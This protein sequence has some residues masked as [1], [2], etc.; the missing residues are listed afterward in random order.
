MA[1]LREIEDAT[2]LLADNHELLKLRVETLHNLLEELKREHIEAIKQAA[3]DTANAKGALEALIDDSR[4]LFAKPKS[5]I[6]SGIRV[7]LKKGSGKVEYED[8]ALVIK[9][10][11]K[12]F[13]LD[14][15]ETYIKTTEKVKK[16]ALEDLDAATL[17]KLGVTIEG[18]GEVV[19]IKMVAS[20]VDKIVAAM[21][22]GADAGEDE[23]EDAA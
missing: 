22:K 10:L 14:H 13:S 17:K 15:Q 7:G 1:T 8:E 2:R 6:I 12:L 23:L 3:A 9:R 20:D 4:H 19:L 16:K 11:K 5:I 18:N 21:L